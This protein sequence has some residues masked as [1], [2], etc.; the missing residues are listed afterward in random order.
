MTPLILFDI[1]GR[2]AD[3]LAQNNTV[4]VD[5]RDKPEI[6]REVVQELKPV[7]EHL[8]NNEP[9]YRSNV[10]LGAIFSIMGGTATI[11]TLWINGVPL[12]WEAYGTPALAVWG[13]AQALY[14]R[15]VAKKPLGA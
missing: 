13:G 6:K 11:G 9:W 12:S 3:R 1:A 8:T 7:I 10:T 4:P 2:I 14:G 15:W 5:G